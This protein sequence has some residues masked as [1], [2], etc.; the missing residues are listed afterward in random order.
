MY[1]YVRNLTDEDGKT[2]RGLYIAR[3]ALMKKIRADKDNPD[4][5]I[6]E[7]A[8]RETRLKEIRAQINKLAPPTKKQKENTRKMRE[9]RE[10][11]RKEKK[12][13]KQDKEKKKEKKKDKIQ[14]PPGDPANDKGKGKKVIKDKLKEQA[15]K[16][17]K[18]RK[19]IA[20]VLKSTKKA[21]KEKGE[22][23]RKEKERKRK[24]K[25][26]IKVIKHMIN[27]GATEHQKE[28]KEKE[29][30]K[31]RKEKE[32]DEKRKERD[33]K[34]KEK[35]EKE[36][37]EKKNTWIGVIL[38]MGLKGL[39]FGIYFLIKKYKKEPKGSKSN[40]GKSKLPDD[41]EDGRWC[42]PPS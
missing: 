12:K 19:R 1:N 30:E 34:E 3:N 20:E 29:E 22:K 28:E 35:R 40:G 18:E 38:I 24:S 17:E 23:E 7:R 5:T 10:K 8:K 36:P 37:E 27:E 14:I 4:I 6:E 9:K 25:K 26:V 11:K 42:V 15:I 41:K 31:K 39:G 2:L 13:E 32:K 16:H 21:K 33:E